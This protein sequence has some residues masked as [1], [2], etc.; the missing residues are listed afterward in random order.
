[1]LTS[2]TFDTGAA[3]PRVI[4]DFRFSNS[5]LPFPLSFSAR[6]RWQHGGNLGPYGTVK[7]EITGSQDLTL[8]GVCRLHPMNQAS[9]QISNPLGPTFCGMRSQPPINP[10]SHDER[11]SSSLDIFLLIRAQIKRQFW[12]RRRVTRE[13]VAAGAEI[14]RE[15]DFILIDTT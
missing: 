13:R 7:K 9:I 8:I 14:E 6:E 5:P 3:E 2:P 1:M 4:A 10:T 15:R 12:R 11:L